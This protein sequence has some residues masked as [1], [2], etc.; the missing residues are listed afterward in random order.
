MLVWNWVWGHLLRSSVVESRRSEGLRGRW[1]VSQGAMRPDGVVMAAPGFDQDLG[2]LQRRE[3]F[4]AQKFVAQ[5]AVEGLVVAVLPWTAGFD[6]KCPDADLTEPFTHR[7]RDE[8]RSVVG[9][10]VLRRSMLDEEIRECFE[11]VA[12]VQT[13]V[14]ADG[15]ARPAELV[16]DSEH[17]ELLSVLSAVL[18]KVISPD[19]M[20]A[21]R[22]Q[23]YA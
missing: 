21:L 6:V 23:P 20:A 5:L 16:D 8:L 17:A 22:S 7:R 2:L 9:T 3:D 19:V 4:P 10:D 12:A 13:P 18:D 1:S 14:D 15:Q 11:H